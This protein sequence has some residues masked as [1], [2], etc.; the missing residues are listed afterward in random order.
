MVIFEHWT[1]FAALY[2]AVTW[3]LYI[4]FSGLAYWLLWV[5]G[6]RS[7][8]HFKIEPH[9]PRRG[10]VRSEIAW[11]LASMLI[12]TAIATLV[13]VAWQHDL[14]PLL[15]TDVGE[16]GWGYF[17]LSVLLMVLLH[18]AWFYWT[19]RLLHLPWL[20]RH[21]HARHHR[22]RPP[23]PWS[24]HSFHPLEA[25][26]QISILPV[27][28]FVMPAHPAAILVFIVVLKIYNTIGHMGYELFPR[29]FGRHWLFH[30]SNAATHHD[31]HHSHVTGHF[32]LYFNFW[33]RVMGTNLPDYA[34]V[35][36]RVTSQRPA[37]AQAAGA[38]E[39]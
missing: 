21:V 8:A 4:A 17:W 32:G 14:T 10:Q 20:F 30:W 1:E 12:F 18:D 38:A 29:A 35:F 25:V 24:T 6:R 34:A 5:R 2:F 19:H 28:V 16:H 15:Y 7:L 9:W 26:V 39:S 3:S 33:D 36:D 37:R 23:T 13:Y 27:I 22:S 11:S 31:M